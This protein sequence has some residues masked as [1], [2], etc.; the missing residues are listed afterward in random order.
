MKISFKKIGLSIFFQYF[1]FAAISQNI[2]LKGLVA[3]SISHQ[4]IGEVSISVQNKEG[5]VIKS[6]LSKADGFFSLTVNRATASAIVFTSLQYLSKKIYLS[7]VESSIND[8]GLIVLKSK[9]ISLEEVV[10]KG[11]RAPLS[12]KVD[13]K[14]F[15]ASSYTNASNGTGVDLVRNLPSISVNGQEKFY[16]EDQIVFWC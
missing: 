16:F 11:K 3:D 10:V 13:R 4:P 5:V 9:P 6:Y 2:V 14:I 12:F 7:N 15:K 1:C 8:W